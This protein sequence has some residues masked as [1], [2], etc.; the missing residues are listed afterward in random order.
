MTPALQRG[1]HLSTL[2]FGPHRALLW[3]WSRRTRGAAQRDALDTP[4]LLYYRAMHRSASVDLD[5]G[6]EALEE[7][8]RPRSDLSWLRYFERSG[9]K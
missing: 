6:L 3:Q 8:R 4:L 5:M 1:F 9:P 2:P 7:Y